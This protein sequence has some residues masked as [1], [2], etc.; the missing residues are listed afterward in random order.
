Q[1]E[2]LRQNLEELA[3]TQEEMPR[4]QDSLRL[5]SARIASVIDHTP[6]LIYAIDRDYRLTMFNQNF[7]KV[8]EEGYGKTP[9][10]GDYV[11]DYVYEE[12][13]ATRK[14]E[15]DRA[16]AGEAFVQESRIVEETGV[17]YYENAFTPIR[18]D[19]GEIV[20]VSVFRR[21]V[22]AHVRAEEAL[23]RSR[24]EL[25]ALNRE[26]EERVENRTR[27]LRQTLD[28]LR[29]SENRLAAII[30]QFPLGFA[31]FSPQGELL[32]T[33]PAYFRITGRRAVENYN[34]LQD[35][36][37]MRREIYLRE[38]FSGN[39]V[40]MP[41]AAFR[42]GRDTVMLKTFAFPIKDENDTLKQV[43]FLYDD[44]SEEWAATDEAKAS[45]S[46]FRHVVEHFP[47][48]MRFYRP[49]GTPL[50][51]NPAY[52]RFWEGRRPEYF[53]V[54]LQ[55]DPV[56]RE[57]GVEVEAALEGRSCEFDPIPYRLADE[58]IWIKSYLFPLFSSDGRIR[59]IVLVQQDVS[60]VK[61]A[62]EAYA[63]ANAALR[64]TLAE[65]EGMRGRVLRSDKMVVLGQMTAGVAHEINSPV[66]ALSASVETAN[67]RFGA[68][69]RTLA[70]NWM[71]LESKPTTFPTLLLRALDAP[72]SASGREERQNR[73]ELAAAF[74][75]AALAFDDEIV[76]CCQEIGLKENEMADL[77]EFLTHAK[78]K[79]RL[80]WLVSVVQIKR[81]LEN[82]RL[83]AEKIRTLALSIKRYTHAAD[84]PVAESFDLAE[85]LKD[86]LNIYA[87]KLK[88]LDLETDLSPA[89]MESAYA[90]ELSQ[91]WTN[92]IANAVQAV[93]GIS[94]PRLAVVLKSD[95]QTA[96]VSIIDNGP[97]VAPEIQDR[98]FDPFF[99]TKKTGEGT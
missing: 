11:F 76:R 4:I 71:D 12:N 45:E 98:I 73:K 55:E 3:A 93:E 18:D 99:T 14:A 20:G 78:A 26:L 64:A 91:V 38:A 54:K 70:E 42:R 15:Y 83:A 53:G 72:P 37:E 9:E 60:E 17:E 57:N 34:I 61:R 68:V 40:E 5:Q 43:V 81:N 56:W 44:V 69:M 24:A 89:V 63:R 58:T 80:Q 41:V 50:F 90:G 16:L 49:D 23:E 95:G 32:L 97:G 25:W 67:A 35:P 77:K 33:N 28:N 48:A 85:N 29:E 47:L 13:R 59:E 82:A 84:V 65:M 27:A 74:A 96:E 21:D 79:E 10:I 19:R 1:E 66:G 94:N 8:I 6:E 51:D 92:L 36:D 88:K 86:V 87:F 7:R 31:L 46:R 30:E 52:I 62:Q 22:S 2:E 39:V 75:Q